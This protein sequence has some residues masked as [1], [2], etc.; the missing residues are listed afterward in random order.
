MGRRFRVRLGELR[1]DAEVHPGLPRGMAP[2]PEAFLQPFVASLGPDAQRLNATGYV[3]GLVSD[4]GAK[5]AEALACLHDRERQGLQE[6]IGQADWDH[7]PLLSESSRQVGAEL[8]EPDG[9]LVFGPPAFPKKGTESVG[10]QRQWCGRLGKLENCQVGIY[11]APVT[12]REHAL[13]DVRPYLPG[14]WGTRTRRREAG[15][16][17]AIRSRTRHELALGML[18]QSGPALPHAWV[19]GDGEMGRSSWFRG[20]CGRGAIATCWPCRRTPRSATWPRRTRRTP[21]A[22]ARR[23]PLR[24][25]G[26]VGHRRAGG[27][28]AGGRG[29]GR[30]EGAG[31]GAGRPD[32]GAG[33]GRQPG[34]GGGRTVGGAPGAAGRRHPGARLPAVQRPAGAVAGGVRARVQGAAPGREDPSRLHLKEEVGRHPTDRLSST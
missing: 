28:V 20:S 6:F 26:P 30:G 18:D 24:A 25:G 4:L 2:R 21:G 11:L 27:G 1:D 16:P 14:G 3:R 22:A 10:V 23:P 33:P 15:V 9:V 13:A 5:A 34:V 7:R 32:A 29:P 8:V 31:G 12:R 17:A 19:S